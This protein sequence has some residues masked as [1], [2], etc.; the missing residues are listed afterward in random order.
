MHFRDE[1]GERIK[2]FSLCIRIV[3]EEGL[4]TVHFEKLCPYVTIFTAMALKLLFQQK[5]QTCQLSL[6]DLWIQMVMCSGVD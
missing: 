4:T 2:V 5:V 6:L 3:A 1:I